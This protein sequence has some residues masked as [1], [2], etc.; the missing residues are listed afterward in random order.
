MHRD[1]APTGD[2]AGRRM[3]FW[4]DYSNALL[5]EDGRVVPIEALALSSSLTAKALA[6]LA[7]YDDAKLDPLTQDDAWIA[8]G[9]QLFAQVRDALAARGIE[10]FDWEGRWGAPGA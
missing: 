2:D 1:N 8:Q 9:R 7:A 6:W 5:H 4:P 3:E 10:V